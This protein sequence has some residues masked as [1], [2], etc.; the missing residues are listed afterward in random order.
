[1][2]KVEE[3]TP[4]EAAEF[5][6][7]EQRLSKP[8]APNLRDAVRALLADAF[9]AIG[10]SLPVGITD[11]AVFSCRIHLTIACQKFGLAVR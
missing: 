11:A 1:M 8:A 9:R 2:S 10:S 5:R 7:L 4:P 3:V 6:V